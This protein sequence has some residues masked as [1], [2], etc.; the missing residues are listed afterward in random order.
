ML[1]GINTMSLLAEDLPGAAPL[2]QRGAGDQ[3]VFQQRSGGCGSGHVEFR[4][5]DYEHELGIIDWP[6]AP[7]ERHQTGHNR[8]YLG[9]WAPAL[10]RSSRPPAEKQESRACQPSP[11]SPM[12][13]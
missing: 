2:V 9:I 7:P 10:E 3:A 6:F 12:P 1:V 13:W 5:G 11:P 4:I 8:H